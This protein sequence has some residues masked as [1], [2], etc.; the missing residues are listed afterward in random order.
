MTRPVVLDLREVVDDEQDSIDELRFD[1]LT[2]ISST[3]YILR[4]YKI[5]NYE[6]LN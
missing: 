2:N 6:L 1:V 4:K 3:D 5:V